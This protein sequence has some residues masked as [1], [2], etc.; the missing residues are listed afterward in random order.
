VLARIWAPVLALCA[1]IGWSRVYLGVHHPSDVLG[2]AVAGT[3]MITTCA[4]AC[5]C[6]TPDKS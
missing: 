5:N 1:L 2:G 6:L 3:I 4:A